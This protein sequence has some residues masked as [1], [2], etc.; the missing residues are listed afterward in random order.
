MRKL[1]GRRL[2]EVSRKAAVR[3]R[4]VA[5]YAENLAAARIAN[6]ELMYLCRQL[7]FIYD[8]YRRETRRLHKQAGQKR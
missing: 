7:A 5:R 4:R 1:Q 6:S 2:E 3:R 8:R